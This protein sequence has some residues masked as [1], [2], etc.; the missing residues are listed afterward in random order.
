MSKR[1]DR[2]VI[3]GA[4]SAGYLA[5]V[6][7]RRR[8]PE[9]RVSLIHSP[10]IPII[11]VGEST[12]AFFPTYLHTELGLDR[13]QFYRDVRP[14]WKMGVQFDWCEP[15][16][17]HFYYSFDRVMDFKSLHLRKMNAYYCLDDRQDCAHFW[18]LMDR[19]LSPC[20]RVPGGFYV[21]DFIGYHIENRKFVAYLKNKAI[22]LGVEIISGD[23][24]EVPLEENGDVACLVL[25][26]GRRLT[27]DLFVDCSGFASLLVGKTLGDPYTSYAKALFCDSA[28]V[29][30]WKREDQILPY[31]RSE[32][33]DN[34]WC[35]QIE[36]DDHVTRGYV[37]S[38]QA[39]STD[40]AMR[41]LKTKNPRLPDDLRVVK[42]PSGRYENFWRNNV[43]AIGNA[44]GFVEPL[45]AT[46]L[47]LIAEQLQHLCGAL[48]ESNRFVVPEAREARCRS[49][50]RHWDEIHDFLALHYKFNRRLDTPFWRHCR[51]DTPLGTVQP[52]VDFYQRVGPSE[53]C[54]DLVPKQSIFQLNGY[55]MLLI[56]LDVPTDYRNDFSPQ[57][58][59]NWRS[60]RNQVLAE[61]A[62][63]LT[64][65]DGLNL[66]HDPRWRWPT[67]GV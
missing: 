58:Q 43:V 51:N 46:A 40:Q 34:G 42:F 61:I 38:S 32:T 4:G 19:K 23:V 59:A 48:N 13:T 60:Y 8:L 9:V 28:I 64:V 62:P 44:S 52:L 18:A 10:R 17:S 3:L 20:L 35:W 27:A 67:T 21:Q 2:A 15:R 24:V 6:A 36:F 63:A 54:S 29:G 14:S 26:D 45:E 66:V 12:T 47:H 55:L 1:V 37:F 7:L 5:A 50:R 49:I 56:G 31:T 30:S 25:D 39:C 33:M 16:D 11:G 22:E 41:E 65:R 53:A 57:D